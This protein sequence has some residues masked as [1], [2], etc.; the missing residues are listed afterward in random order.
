MLYC[1]FEYP[2]EDPKQREARA[3][4]HQAWLKE[5]HADK[6]RAAC[7]ALGAETA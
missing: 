2:P 1:M 7:Y 4:K 5:Q 6:F 3:R